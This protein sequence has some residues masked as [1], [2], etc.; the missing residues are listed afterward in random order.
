[1]HTW[2]K[3]KHV[4]ACVH[5]HSSLSTRGTK[6]EGGKGF[7]VTHQ[8]QGYSTLDRV[9]THQTTDPRSSLAPSLSL[10]LHCVVLKLRG[11]GE[12]S[13]YLA[14]KCLLPDSS[15]TLS[16]RESN[17]LICNENIHRGYISPCTHYMLNPQLGQ[18]HQIVG[19]FSAY[20]ACPRWW[21]MGR[22]RQV[23]SSVKR[24]TRMIYSVLHEQRGT[25]CN[26][27]VK[28]TLVWTS[29]VCVCMYMSVYCMHA[30]L[31]VW[32][33]PRELI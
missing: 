10:T 26:Y 3:T 27:H 13:I 11:L 9:R 1:M 19:W 12:K 14:R 6:K 23:C 5:D 17:D 2:P 21:V 22:C 4:R 20:C 18:Y 32:L 31:S 29:G 30:L 33:S 16:G 7:K 24:A 15:K 25:S 28:D 8:S